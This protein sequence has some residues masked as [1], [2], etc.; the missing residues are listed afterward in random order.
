MVLR[1]ALATVLVPAVAHAGKLTAGVS[2]GSSHDQKHDDAGI[3]ASQTVGLFARLALTPKLSGQ[4]ELAKY[5]HADGSGTV[6]RTATALLVFDLTAGSRWVPT[7]LF[8]VGIDR[9]DSVMACEVCLAGSDAQ[10]ARHIEGGLGIE[11]RAEGGLSFG[12]DFRLGGRSLDDDAIEDDLLIVRGG[13][14]QASEYRA[15]RIWAG[16]RF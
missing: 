11:Y 6:V 9:A 10:G 15:G 3:G 7:L 5:D 1:L 14:L 8:G 16:I 2:V 13:R 4:L 12:A